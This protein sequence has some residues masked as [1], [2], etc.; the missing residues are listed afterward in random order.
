ESREHAASRATPQQLA[1]INGIRRGGGAAHV[2]VSAAEALRAIEETRERGTETARAWYASTTGP[3]RPAPG[4]R[5]TTGP[6]PRAATCSPPPACPRGPPG[7]PESTSRPTSS[8]AMR[9][10]W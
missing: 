3:E 9:S 10:T 4:P 6:P 2:V 7:T 5:R 1:Q 8:T